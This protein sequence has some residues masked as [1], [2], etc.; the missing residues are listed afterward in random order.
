MTEV[1]IPGQVDSL[2][3]YLFWEID[4][5]MVVIVFASVGILVSSLITTT[6]AGMVCARMLSR[7]KQKSLPGLTL[8]MAYWIGAVSL[9]PQFTNGA[10]REIV[11]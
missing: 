10:M 1:D 5:A 6:I 4:E 7:N 9:G 11:E 3:Q 2:P 8:H